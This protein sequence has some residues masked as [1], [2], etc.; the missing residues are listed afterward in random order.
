MFAE[1]IIWFPHQASTTAYSVD[2]FLYFLV[3]VCGSVGLL[4][5]FML[6]YF[7]V[8]YRRRP[9]DRPPP[10]VEGLP[11]IEVVWT[12]VPMGFFI[13]FFLWGANIYFAAYR[14]PDDAL[15]IYGEGT[16]WMWK[17]QQL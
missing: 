8:R 14:A 6:I 5:A 7:S 11:G 13:V 2:L 10:R 17:F 4:V 12:V 3:A 9:G 16:Q 15:V 1:N